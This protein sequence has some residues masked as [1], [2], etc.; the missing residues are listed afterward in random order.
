MTPLVPCLVCKRHIRV[1]HTTCPFCGGAV[2]ESF[3]SGIIPAARRRLDR[4][5]LFTF[6]LAFGGAA[7]GQIADDGESQSGG[8]GVVAPEPQPG[9][10]AAPDGDWGGPGPM[11][12]AAP[13]PDGGKRLVD[14]AADA[15][16]DAGSTF[17]MYGIPPWDAGSPDAHPV[18]DAEA[19]DGGIFV[20]Y[21]MPPPSDDGGEFH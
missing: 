13:Q 9:D 7:C 6:A 18:L 10:A 2:P 21:G 11:Y 17:V 20:L 14:A 5:A 19:D 1:D 12:G 4:V 15:D 8:Q 3:A 16:G